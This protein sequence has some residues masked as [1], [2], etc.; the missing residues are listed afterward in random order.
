MISKARFAA[1]SLF[2][3]GLT[4]NTISGSK[5]YLYADKDA[6][7]VIEFLKPDKIK[8]ESDVQYK[9]RIRHPNF[10]E[11]KGNGPRFVEFYAPWCPH[12][13]HFKPTYIDVARKITDVASNVKFYAVACTTHY[14]ICKDRGVKGYPTIKY[15][16]EGNSTGTL[17]VRSQVNVKDLMKNYITA[18]IDSNTDTDKVMKKDSKIIPKPYH[19]SQIDKTVKTHALTNANANIYHDATS[20]FIYALHNSIF[21]TSKTL[22]NSEADAFETW[23]RLLSKT[24]PYTMSDTKN[25]ILLLLD[26]I[27][28]IVQNEN[29]MLDILKERISSQ[30]DKK[31]SNY[32]NDVPDIASE[33]WT[34]ACAH[35]VPASGYTCGLWELFHI[36]T[37]GLVEENYKLSKPISTMH[38]AESLNKYVEHF[39]ACEECRTNFMDMY[40][41]CSFDRCNRLN[42]NETK[43]GDIHWKQLPLWLW[44]V[45][46][47]VNMRLM[48][49]EKIRLGLPEPTFKEQQAVVWPSK[50]DC[51]V[52]WNDDGTWQENEVY[53][54]LYQHYWPTDARTVAYVS[55]K[56]TDQIL[57][58]SKNSLSR[59]LLLC[60]AMSLFALWLTVRTRKWQK[61][62]TGYHKK[63]DDCCV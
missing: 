42:W 47:D 13:Q 7:P 25:T 54:Y 16:S 17:V 14:D 35:S 4:S 22:S 27:T 6:T 18:K 21:M 60:I 34:A 56:N 28:G 1:L 59:Y 29:I 26:D 61:Y 62:L 19:G 24:L 51:Q 57:I 44:E 45:H 39:F 43:N 48:T 10:L 11:G 32:E 40:D 31:T 12:C 9:L 46:N 3:T 52:C 50:N 36:M 20:S 53:F 33:G 2:L 63:A 55:Q 38:A 58:T 49:E 15:F 30:R 23:I 8:S 37:I 41:S 5:E